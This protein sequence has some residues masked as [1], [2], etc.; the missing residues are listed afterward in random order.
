[1]NR[2]DIDAQANMKKISFTTIQKPDGWMASSTYCH[3]EID[4]CDPSVL[5]ETALNDSYCKTGIKAE[6]IL[7]GPRIWLQLTE[8]K[9]EMERQRLSA[10]PTLMPQ[11]QLDGLSFQ[12]YCGPVKI[13]CVAMEVLDKQPQVVLDSK[14]ESTSFEY[15]RGRV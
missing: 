11:P 2:Y 10:S 4:A 7:V 3:N 8:H 12:H 13:I 9:R 15:W 6:Y 14:H 5:L 1:M